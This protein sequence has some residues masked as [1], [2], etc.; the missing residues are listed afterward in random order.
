MFYL[1]HRRGCGPL[2]NDDILYSPDI[3]VF[4]TDHSCPALL[5]EEEWFR[6]DVLTCAAPN[7]RR[8]D[9]TDPY[10][11]QAGAGEMELDRA[12]LSGLLEK[13]T[14]RILE[15]AAAESRE[16]LILGAFG[17]GAFRNPPGIVA[18]AFRKALEEFGGYFETVEF[19][20][21][22]AERERE[23]FEAFQ[24]VFA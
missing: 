23:N 19:A 14:R 7:L 12:F 15:A 2:Y 18:E 5:P 24:S 6:T 17:C 20:V 3:T 21:F 1:P 16:V 22:H 11:G 8:R 4:K 13:R 10:T 9:E